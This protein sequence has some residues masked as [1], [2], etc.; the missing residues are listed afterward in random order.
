MEP[1]SGVG[2]ASLLFRNADRFW[3]EFEGRDLSTLS[4]GIEFVD[5]TADGA[6]TADVLWAQIPALPPD[7]GAPTLLTLTA[8]GNDLLSLLGLGRREGQREVGRLIERLHRI[9][10]DLLARFDDPTLLVGTVYDPSDGRAHLGDGVALLDGFAW[11]GEYNGEVRRIAARDGCRLAD[12]HHHFLG[13]G[14]SEPDPAKRWYWEGSIIE[15]GA[16]GASEVRRL[17][18]ECLGV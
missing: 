7:D 5:L 15:P 12:I 11:L 10:D 6:T 17:W 1:P 9:V 14:L 16:R 18:L 8:G 13:H 2:A 3:P 4:P